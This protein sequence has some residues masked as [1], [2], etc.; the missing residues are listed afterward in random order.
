MCLV[1]DLSLATVFGINTQHGHPRRKQNISPSRSSLFT[2]TEMSTKRSRDWQA[3]YDSDSDENGQLPITA[4]VD[5]NGVISYTRR[6][7]VT[8]KARIYDIPSNLEDSKLELD[9]FNS[10]GSTQLTLETERSSRKKASAS[11]LDRLYVTKRNI[12]NSKED[13]STFRT[14]HRVARRDIS[15]KTRT[16]HRKSVCLQQSFT[17]SGYLQ[18]HRM[19]RTRT[20]MPPL[21]GSRPSAHAAALDSE[22]GWQSIRQGI[23]LQSPPLYLSRAQLAS[24]SQH[25]NN[26]SRS[27]KTHDDHSHKWSS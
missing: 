26:W 12:G 15:F 18:V 27:G 19:L 23:S 9:G 22:M 4:S 13:G 10:S 2:L 20:I 24:L 25:L 7:L 8:Q 14:F 16:W 17:A 21:H 1:L 5:Q 3:Y 11:S 6:P